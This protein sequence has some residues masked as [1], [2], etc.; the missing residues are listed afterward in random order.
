MKLVK[1]KMRDP[2]SKYSTHVNILSLVACGLCQNLGWTSESTQLKLGLAAL[3]HD[4]TVDESY[5]ASINYWNTSASS[6]ND[7]R[8]EVEQYRNH[9][10]D[11]AH[12]ILSM[13]NIPA[14]VDQIILQHHE[15]P[16]GT[17]FPRKILSSR[18]TPMA[19]VFILTEDLIQFIGDSQ[20]VDERIL[21]FLKLRE[22]FYNS[23]NFR[24][25]FEALRDSV[26]KTHSDS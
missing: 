6:K 2:E 17:G 12:L 23:G 10:N 11:A 15:T 19:S 26:Q 20:D 9:P 7:H 14:D 24:K 1:Q 25:V 13:K 21:S 16:D 4:L 5:Y 8:P 3:I 22:S 18:I